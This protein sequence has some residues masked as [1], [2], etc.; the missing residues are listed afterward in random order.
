M[1]FSDIQDNPL[2]YDYD[3]LFDK[4]KNYFTISIN[5]Y[6]FVDYLQTNNLTV[7]THN[8]TIEPCNVNIYIIDDPI[9]G[10]KFKKAYL[11]MPE[12]SNL[13]D[14]TRFNTGENRFS[15]DFLQKLM[16][17]TASN[18]QFQ[19]QLQDTIANIALE[20]ISNCSSAELNDMF[21]EYFEDS[22]DNFSI[23]YN[24]Y[25]RYKFTSS[26]SIKVYTPKDEF[27][28]VKSNLTDQWMLSDELP[29]HLIEKFKE[30]CT[31]LKNIIFN[32]PTELRLALNEPL[33]KQLVPYLDKIKNIVVTLEANNYGPK[34]IIDN[35]YVE[36]EEDYDYY[37]YSGTR[38]K[39]KLNVPMHL[40]YDDKNLTVAVF[41]VKQG[42]SIKPINE[43]MDMLQNYSYY[44]KSIKETLKQLYTKDLIEQELAPKRNFIRRLIFSS[45]DKTICFKED[46]VFYKLD[47]QQERAIY[48]HNNNTQ[49]TFIKNRND[50]EISLE[51]SDLQHTKI[52]DLRETIYKLIEKF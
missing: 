40:E 19:N 33:P 30:D 14:T 35:N 39:L 42:Q 34:W 31:E 11:P 23:G 24:L 22:L 12:L 41:P 52:D 45:N 25:F 27:E 29:E 5:N 3:V 44:W 49:I 17:E 51:Y 20:N 18:K 26:R 6:K 7:M 47:I 16:C 8:E 4:L 46:D 10:S 13:W 50:F 21:S 1:R 15:K 9:L 2:D 38:Y 32:Q 48:Y 36:D 43:A 37:L 28:L